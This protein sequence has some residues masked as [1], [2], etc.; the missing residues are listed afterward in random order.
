M[1]S[2]LSHTFILDEDIDGVALMG[3]QDTDIVKLLSKLNEDG[4][5][6]TPTMRTQRKFKTILEEY[7]TLAKQERKEK[8]RNR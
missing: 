2:I 5:I 8:R 1:V 6:R 7:R 4:T 3:L